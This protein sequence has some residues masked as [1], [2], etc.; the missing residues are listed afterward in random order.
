MGNIIGTSTERM[1]SD[2]TQYGNSV[3]KVDDAL[4]N[5]FAAIEALHSTWSGP[6]HD[7]LT[8]QF[9][10]DQSV[11]MDVLKDLREYGT[12]LENAKTEYE[13]CESNVESLINSMKV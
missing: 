13:K 11:M 2:I 7:T 8:A 3:Q 10:A 1:K 6:A 12:D 5:A 9:A 4:K